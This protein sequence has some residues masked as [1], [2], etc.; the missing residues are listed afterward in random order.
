MPFF[1]SGETSPLLPSQGA[2][3]SRGDV[4]DQFCNLVGVPP[5]D[6]PV[7]K[8][9]SNDRSLYERAVQG[10]RSQNW[11][12]QLTASISNTLLLSQVIIGAALTGLGASNSSHILITV[13]GASNTIIAG[14]V[15]YLK[16]RGQPMYV[17]IR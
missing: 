15:A 8:W 6:R 10:K 14:L 1:S 12:Y 11:T 17:Y 4:H 2:N 13:L 9:R 3:Y 7:A 5:S 16:S